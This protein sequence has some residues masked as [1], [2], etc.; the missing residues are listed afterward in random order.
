MSLLLSILLREQQFQRQQMSDG[1]V[2]M[3]CGTDVGSF[4]TMHYHNSVLL[5]MA[6]LCRQC[7][8]ETEYDLQTVPRVHKNGPLA[9]HCYQE[10]KKHDVQPER[11]VKVCGYIWRDC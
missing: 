6:I 2:H 7:S 3:T 1:I 5:S 4:S 10:S 9:M 11:R 8:P